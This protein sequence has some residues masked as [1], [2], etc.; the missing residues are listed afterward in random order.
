M[1]DESKLSVI[2]PTFNEEDNLAACME[3]VRWADEIL[4]ADAFSTDRTLDIARSFPNVRIIQ[5][6]YK[7]STSQ[8]NWAIPQARHSWILIVDADERISPELA[9]EIKDIVYKGRGSEDIAAYRIRRNSYFLGKRIRYCGWQNDYVIRLFRKGKAQYEYKFVHG[10][11][12]VDGRT[13]EL[14]NR[15]EHYT[16]R[17]LSGYL[18]KIEKYTAWA[19]MEKFKKRKKV[20][21]VIIGVRTCFRF[22]RD[23][24]LRLGFLDGT[25]GFIL[26][27][28][29]AFAEFM[30]LSKLWEMISNARREKI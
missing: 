29:S 21:I 5:R 4:L 6:E 27:G 9:Q 28:L 18:T 14:D 26:C 17:T 15:I 19:A 25:Y 2:I 20:N 24:I 1:A 7:Y 8:K 30:K 10:K 23:Y 13:G 16:I 22:F 3:G 11:L 12:I